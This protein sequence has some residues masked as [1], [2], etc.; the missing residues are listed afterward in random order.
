MM[1]TSQPFR[2][3]NDSKRGSIDVLNRAQAATA[4]SAL[5]G[6]PSSG[7]YRPGLRQSLRSGR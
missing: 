7:T 4:T 2:S 3:V 5:N 1:M 6:T